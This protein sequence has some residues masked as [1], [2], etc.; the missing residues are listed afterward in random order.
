MKEM[1]SWPVPA[2]GIDYDTE[3]MKVEAQITR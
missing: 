3:I 2:G 1:F